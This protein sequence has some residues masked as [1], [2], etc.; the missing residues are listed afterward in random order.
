MLVQHSF[1][2]IPSAVCRADIIQLHLRQHGCAQ[3]FDRHC[4]FRQRNRNRWEDQVSQK[5][6]DTRRIGHIPARCKQMKH[7]TK[8]KRDQDARKKRRNRHDHL[9]DDQD[10]T[11]HLS[12][13]VMRAEQT[14]RN[15]NR[16][17]DQKGHRRKRQ[18]NRNLFGDHAAHRHL[19]LVGGSKISLYKID[20]PAAK[21]H[22]ERFI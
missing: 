2:I 12:T 22:Q 18:R 7:K 20:R 5:P 11:I 8:Q 19:I 9:I 15:R 4:R 16:H 14:D 17:H 1:G 6:C 3:Q 13:R 21:A 10:D